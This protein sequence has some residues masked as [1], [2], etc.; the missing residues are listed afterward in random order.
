M[1]SL[2]GSRTEANVR[3][4][5]SG[6]VQSNRRYFSYAELA[7]A[8]GYRDLAAQL[9]TKAEEAAGHAFGH[10]DYLVADDTGNAKQTA[11]TTMDELTSAAAEMSEKSAATY[12]GMARTA[13]EDGFDD[14]ADWF[15]TLAKAEHAQIRRWRDVRDMP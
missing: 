12:A 8:A 10:L 1:L 14:L 11:G 5:L 7:V 13:H 6:E 4:A 9:R 3:R 2:K 15:E